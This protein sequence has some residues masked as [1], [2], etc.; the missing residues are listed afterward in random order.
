MKTI[1][2]VDD[3]LDLVWSLS[4]GLAKSFNTYRILT[5]GNTSLALKHLREEQVDILITDYRLPDGDGINIIIEAQ[6]INPGIFPIL[7]TAYGSN[8]LQSLLIPISGTV[9]LEK[10]FEIETLRSIIRHNANKSILSTT[11]SPDI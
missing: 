9:Y 8:D 10:P 5:A 2:I 3:E 6:A 1:L 11:V 7:M 4:R